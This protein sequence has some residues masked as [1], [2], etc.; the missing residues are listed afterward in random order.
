MCDRTTRLDR[1][2]HRADLILE[3][4]T[5]LEPALTAVARLTWLSC[6][7]LAAPTSVFAIYVRLF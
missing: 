2:R 5:V 3:Y 4:C 7:I 6:R 1:W